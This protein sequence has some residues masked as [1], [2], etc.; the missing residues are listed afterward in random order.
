MQKVVGSNPISRFPRKP[1]PRAGFCVFGAA[2]CAYVTAHLWPKC[3]RGSESV[4]LGRKRWASRAW[5]SAGAERTSTLTH[6]RTLADLDAVRSVIEDAAVHLH[7]VAY[8]LRDRGRSWAIARGSEWA[9]SSGSR[10]PA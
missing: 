6:E 7:R 10:M 4:R 8:A 2:G 1:A 9:G 5:P 3:L